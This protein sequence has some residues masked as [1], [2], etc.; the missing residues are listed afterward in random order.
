MQAV[1][2]SA[3]GPAPLAIVVPTFNEG[4][5]VA[6][7]VRR[8]HQVLGERDWEV[9][10]VDDDSPDGTARIAR[11]LA[12]SDR[13]VRCVQRVGRR[14]LSSACIEGVLATSAPLIAI[15]DADL[16]HDEA[17]LPVMWSAFADTELDVV[18]GSR[19]IEGGDVG[20]WSESRQRASR[21]ATHLG[22]LLVPASLRDPMSGFFM[23][24]RSTFE[25]CLP[26]LSAVGFKILLDLFASS[27]RELRFVELPYSFRPRMAGESKLDEQVAW[28][29]GMLLA[30]KF[31]GRW[32]PVRFVAFALIG[33][34]GVGV[35]FATLWI[36]H[37]VLQLE[38]VAGQAAATVVAM[39]GNYTINNFITYRDRRHR[40][41]AW[42]WGLLSFSLVCSIG[43]VANVGV[44]SYLFERDGRW[45]LAALA[46]ILVGAVWNYAVT[47]FYTWGSR[48]RK[49]SAAKA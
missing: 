46:G 10:F 29:F 14:G 35:H 36:A 31:V 12:L 44:A 4:G 19:Y 16:Q 23:M 5:N 11:Q 39:A 26:R 22:H 49:S 42:W 28:E 7:L 17:L 24:R 18:V 25:Q 45:V 6:E 38:F 34:L 40:G 27:R 20:A 3:S 30:D 13:R 41:W 21:L 15:M 37:R 9:V 33:L 2:R 1:P 43:A 48:V 8:L 32:I 47:A